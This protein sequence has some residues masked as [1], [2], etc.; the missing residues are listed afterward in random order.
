[1]SMVKIKRV[2]RHIVI[3]ADEY[4]IPTDKFVSMFG[5]TEKFMSE[6]LIDEDFLADFKT[7]ETVDDI[8]NRH[9]DY[10]EEWVIENE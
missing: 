5:S 1:M 4:E 2:Q 8:S 9:G 3:Y 10:E 7:A 6:S